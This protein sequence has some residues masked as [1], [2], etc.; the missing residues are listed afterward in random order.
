MQ[1]KNARNTAPVPKEESGLSRR[2]LLKGALGLSAVAALSGCATADK[3][4][5]LRSRRSAAQ[6]D[7]VRRE[8]ARRGTREWL[9]QK[10]AIDPKAKYRCPWIEGYCSRTSVRPGEAIEFHVSTNPPSRF[11]LDLYRMGYYGGAGG[12]RMK[13]L[14]P[15]RGVTQ[16]D[17]PTGPKRRWDC[18]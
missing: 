11:R 5:S 13:Q 1:R 17:P 7:W 3:V 14:G 2:E 6:P 8:N 10:T 15:F 4:G 16:P 18:A 12:R 9:L